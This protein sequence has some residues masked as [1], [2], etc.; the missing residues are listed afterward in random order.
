M[1]MSAV[2]RGVAAAALLGVCV[3]AHATGTMES[4]RPVFPIDADPT[5]GQLWMKAAGSAVVV[6]DSPDHVYYSRGTPGS[7]AEVPL[8]LPPGS[9]QWLG[10]AV[11]L[12]DV[13]IF[14]AHGATDRVIATD[15]TAGGTFVLNE[16]EQSECCNSALF[17]SGGFVYFASRVGGE[18]VFFRTDGTP[19]GTT[20]LPGIDGLWPVVGGVAALREQGP[21]RYWFMA[22]TANVFEPMVPALP[23]THRL[24]I[25]PVICG[26][27]MAYFEQS[28]MT[29]NTL[30]WQEGGVFRQDATIFSIEPKLLLSD[31][32]SRRV[33]YLS[34]S[35]DVPR[36]PAVWAYVPD[37]ATVVELGRLPSGSECGLSK[38][39]VK[40][41]LVFSMEVWQS[42]QWRRRMWS[43]GTLGG[44]SGYLTDDPAGAEWSGIVV[45]CRDRAYFSAVDAEHGRELWTSDGTPEGT[46]MVADVRPGTRS[47]VQGY[48]AIAV[49]RSRVYFSATDGQDGHGFW[50]LDAEPADFD[51]SASVSVGDVLDF[52]GTYLSGGDRAD[53]NRDGTL[54]VDDIYVWLGEYFAAGE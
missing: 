24:S 49:V 15:G 11:A 32:G 36:G 48:G 27:G 14:Q 46:R 37:S 42:G 5:Y 9:V 3:L 22:D 16:G 23:M 31:S 52:V 20:Q 29:E 12:G 26:G 28:E 13:L 39:L 8:P 51:N 35:S 6:S 50:V 34:S 7:T 44:Y 53:A 18:K 21:V 47:G 41:Q 25:G 33:F 17:V 19:G 54:G 38:V 43:M 2:H 10:R 1:S 40:D 30:W 45:A 4:P